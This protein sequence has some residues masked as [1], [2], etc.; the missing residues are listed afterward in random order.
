LAFSAQTPGRHA[1]P[2]LDA[3]EVAGRQR[4]LFRHP[5]GIGLIEGDREKDIDNASGHRRSGRLQA[6]KKG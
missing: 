5:V 3:H 2:E 4:E 6:I 1:R